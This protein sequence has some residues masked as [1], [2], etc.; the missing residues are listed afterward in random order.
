M[1]G[2]PVLQ[3]FSMLLVV[4]GHNILTN[5]PVDPSSPIASDI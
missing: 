4:V 5:K 1:S 2:S 3:G